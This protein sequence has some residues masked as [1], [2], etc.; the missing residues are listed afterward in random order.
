MRL[1]GLYAECRTTASPFAGKVGPR[2]H[3]GPYFFERALRAISDGFRITKA[4]E[5]GRV[6][7]RGS[8]L[9]CTAIRIRVASK[10]KPG[11]CLA[12]PV[13]AAVGGVDLPV[14]VK[15]TSSMPMPKTDGCP[16]VCRSVAMKAVKLSPSTTY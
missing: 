3:P 9:G 15:L 16:G 12:V 8:A 14:S 11:A 1:A 5:R 13:H 10:V 4:G 7:A 6:G 2:S